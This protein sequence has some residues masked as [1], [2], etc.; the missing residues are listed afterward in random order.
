MAANPK[1][2]IIVSVRNDMAS[3]VRTDSFRTTPASSTRK[4]RGMR[5]SEGGI[6]RRFLHTL[7]QRRQFAL[8]SLKRSTWIGYPKTTRLPQ[9]STL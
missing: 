1:A 6:T 2:G 4:R 8:I 5:R 7:P 9:T 3:S